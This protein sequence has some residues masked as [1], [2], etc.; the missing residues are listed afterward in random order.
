MTTVRSPRKEERAL[1]RA[2]KKLA[3]DEA[4][5]TMLEARVQA[6]R[7]IFERARQALEEAQL[8]E[9]QGATAD[10]TEST[11]G[12]AGEPDQQG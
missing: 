4:K 3:K 5:L 10:L 2:G 6:R 9:S 1:A 7:A 11:G 8:Q 12:E